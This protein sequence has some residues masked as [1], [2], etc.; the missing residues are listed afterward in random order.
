MIH[1]CESVLVMFE[2]CVM[3]CSICEVVAIKVTTDDNIANVDDA[4]R[5][6]RHLSNSDAIGHRSSTESTLFGSTR[7]SAAYNTAFDQSID[8]VAEA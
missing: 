3:C 5:P 2:V 6:Q 1:F 4:S 8:S 7:E